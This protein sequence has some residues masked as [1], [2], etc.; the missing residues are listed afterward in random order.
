MALELIFIIFAGVFLYIQIGNMR[1]KPSAG[2][3][4]PKKMSQQL[5]QLIEYADRLYVE[6]KWLAAEKA[7]LKVLAI[8]HKNITAYSHLGVIYSAQKNMADAVECFEIAVRMKPSAVTLQNLGIAY[9]EN[10][11]YMK[12]IVAFE[13]S[14]AMEPSAHRYIGLSKAQKKIHNINQVI[15]S[16]EKAIEYDNSKKVLQLLAD[17]YDEAGQTAAA[18][19]VYRQIHEIDPQDVEAARWIG[20]HLPDRTAKA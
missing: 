18:T 2:T 14:I 10:K 8:D 6:K 13:K 15:Q 5:S 4:V 16:L 19:K 9:L 17:A 1:A 12:S 3:L 20:V 11:N 7:Y